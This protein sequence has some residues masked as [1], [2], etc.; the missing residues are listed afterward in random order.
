MTVL[1]DFIRQTYFYIVILIGIMMAMNS[2][3]WTDKKSESKIKRTM[4]FLSVIVFLDFL[5]DYFAKI[6][7]YKKVFLVLDAWGLILKPVIILVLMMLVTQKIRK[8]YWVLVGINFVFV[9]IRFCDCTNH[10][11]VYT[12]SFYASKVCCFVLLGLLIKAGVEYIHRTNIREAKLLIFILVNVSATIALGIIDEKARLLNP[13]YA[14]NV[15]FYLV[16][17]HNENSKRDALTN[18]YNRHTL[19]S[20]IEQVGNKINGVIMFDINGFK[21][22]NDKYGHDVGDKILVAIAQTAQKRLSQGSRLYRTGGDEFVIVSRRSHK[23]IKYTAQLIREDFI[24]MGYP[25]AVGV[26]L[27]KDNIIPVEEMIK[28]SDKEMYKDK[29]E[30][31][32]KMGENTD[33]AQ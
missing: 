33:K 28:D 12:V 4:Y 17:L 5:T 18:T 26:R 13:L 19:Y 25:C 3:F 14:I 20:D 15:L 2:M 9:V 30:M 22:I 24:E 21:Q 32:K 1:Y 6:E 23:E 16:Y 10:G 29:V 27:R 31:K 7:R 8:T 11:K